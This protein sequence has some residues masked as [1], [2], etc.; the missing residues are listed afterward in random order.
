[1]TGVR[2]KTVT[3][4]LTMNQIFVWSC[5]RSSQETLGILTQ[6]EW[7]KGQNDHQLI[8]LPSRSKTVLL[9]IFS[10]NTK[11]EIC[12]WF[13]HCV[14]EVKIVMWFLDYHQPGNK[15]NIRSH[16]IHKIVRVG[17]TGSKHTELSLTCHAYF[18]YWA[19]SYFWVNFL[20]LS[21]AYK[22]EFFSVL[23][24]GIR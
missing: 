7:I 19:L 2:A 5:P 16:D 24:K 6:E 13:F 1:M 23:C 15:E 11:L 12:M 20:P 10:A 21:F 4:F 9:H 17:R 3:G 14:K 8:Y 18:R 22:K